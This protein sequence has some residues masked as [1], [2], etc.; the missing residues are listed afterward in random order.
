MQDLPPAHEFPDPDDWYVAY[1]EFGLDH[2]ILYH[3][4]GKSIEH[5]RQ[6]DVLLVGNSQVGYGFPK[7]VLRRAEL[8]TGLTFYNLGFGYDERSTFIS[9]LIEKQDLR[10]KFV[11]AHAILIDGGS[12]FQRDASDFGRKVM[13]SSHWEAWK[14]VNEWSLTWRVRN[15][16][17]IERLPSWRALRPLPRV[18]VPRF[19][20]CR[21]IST[22]S[23]AASRERPIPVPVGTLPVDTNGT[24]TAPDEDTLAIALDFKRAL[25]AR[26]AKLI[27]TCVPAPTNLRQRNQAVALAAALQVPF[28]GPVPDGLVTRDGAHLTDESARRFATRCLADFANQSKEPAQNTD[29]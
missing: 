5:A 19:I 21:S 22:G 2:Y 20:Y 14:T 7:D 27:L 23:W 29:D 9:A 11:I 3:G 24:S 12:F 8:E 15:S 10:P 1:D 28:V 13:A 25:A 4:L 17:L 18:W 6:A 16:H 26:G